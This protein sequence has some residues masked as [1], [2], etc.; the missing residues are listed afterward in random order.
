MPNLDELIKTIKE[1]QKT[2]FILCGFPYAGKSFIA[3]Q[4]LEHADITFVSI[5]NIFQTHGFDWSSNTLP[6]ANTWEQIFG[7][8]YEQTKQTL[9]GGKNV[10]YDS[11]N[12][13]VAS[14]DRLREVARSVEADTKVVYVKSCTENVWKRWEENQESKSRS[15]V[16][17]DL[18][19]MTIDMF[20]EPTEEEDTI[21]VNN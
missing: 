4:L 17:K 6:D 11:T 18:V 15:I 3:E 20:D 7:E 1:S 16:S 21:I 19:Q 5:D 12:Q 14:R 8:S 10:L 2:L 9:V 13:T